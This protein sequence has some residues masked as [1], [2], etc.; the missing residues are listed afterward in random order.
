M[1]FNGGRRNGE[2]PTLK[3]LYGIKPRSTPVF[4]LIT[5]RQNVLD[6][7]TEPKKNGHPFVM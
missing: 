5:T 2:T 3:Q 6:R 4:F 1:T 7:A